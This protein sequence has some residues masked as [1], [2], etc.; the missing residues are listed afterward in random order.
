MAYCDIETP[1]P[2]DIHF[3]HILPRLPGKS[4]HCFLC[5]CKQWWSFLTSPA[6][7]KMH[8]HHRHKLL[9]ALSTT[10]PCKFNTI[11]LEAHQDGLSASRPL[12]FEIL[13]GSVEIIESIR[14]LICL[15]MR[16][17]CNGREYSDIILWNPLTSE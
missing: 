12:P 10:T 5:V 2:P 9:I 4:V 11:D 1:M 15:C 3:S 7:T 13:N 14:G 17:K 8:H 16:N 6:F